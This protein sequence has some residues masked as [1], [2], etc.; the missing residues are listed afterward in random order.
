[1]K[2][3]RLTW[4]SEEGEFHIEDVFLIEEDDAIY[5]VGPRNLPIPTFNL[6]DQ[7]ASQGMVVFEDEEGIFCLPPSDIISVEVLQ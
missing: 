7:M 4:T 5:A 2:L 6:Y 3:V 1:M